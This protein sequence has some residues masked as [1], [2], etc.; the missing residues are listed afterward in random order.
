MADE[1]ET[2][3]EALAQGRYVDGTELY[4]AAE[5]LLK[6]LDAAETRTQEAERKAAVDMTEQLAACEKHQDAAFK[7][8]DAAQARVAELEKLLATECSLSMNTTNAM[9]AA[10]ARVQQ[11][12]KV[13]RVLLEKSPEPYFLSQKR[14]EED[15]ELD[16]MLR[17]LWD[18]ARAALAEVT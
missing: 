7:Q 8:R 6:A 1:F 14:P 18:E 17:P 11:L 9:L 13:L 15:D 4:R 12:E 16:A 5:K 10:Q 2:L 3:R